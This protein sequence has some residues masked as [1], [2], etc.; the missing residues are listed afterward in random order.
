MLRI[1][2]SEVHS[3]GLQAVPW[4]YLGCITTPSGLV[5]VREVTTE[6]ESWLVLRTVIEGNEYIERQ[7]RP[8][9]LTRVGLSRVA[10]WWI[11]D[12]VSRLS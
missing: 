12:L 5:G 2:K 7:E 4:G 10:H 8:R 1:V 11:Q 9:P 6:G 3:Y